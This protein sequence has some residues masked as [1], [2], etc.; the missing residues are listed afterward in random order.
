MESDIEIIVRVFATLRGTLDREQRLMI[1]AGSSVRAI[2]RLLSSRYPGFENT[3]FDSSGGL[4]EGIN[5]LLNG[6]N[7]HFLQGL[8]TPLAAGDVIAL[9]PP[10][11]GG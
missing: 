6:R 10:L 11:D 7:I 5:I 9:F 3:I 1:P 2:L 8:E 4:L